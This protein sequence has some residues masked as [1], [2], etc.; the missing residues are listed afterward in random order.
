MT[1]S[2]STT[3]NN[4]NVKKSIAMQSVELST[5]VPEVMARR[6]GQFMFAG[7]QPNENHQEE[8]E[9]MWSEKS[10]AFV[11]SWQAMAEQTSK[12]NQEIYS[13]VVKAMFTPWWEMNALEVC[14]PKKMN[15]A[16]LSIINK[17]LEPIHAKTTS[18]AERLKNR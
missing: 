11:E 13:S 7:Y 17:G 10:D 6:I 3:A 9:L 5:S 16:A 4:N 2:K 12:I 1:K 14:T 15:K 18:N 8:F